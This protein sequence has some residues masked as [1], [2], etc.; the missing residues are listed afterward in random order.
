M[1]KIFR[2][3]IPQEVIEPPPSLPSEV[4]LR[5]TANRRVQDAAK[6]YT[7]G[8]PPSISLG[9]WSERPSLNVQIKT[10]TDYK[11]GC[12]NSPNSPSGSSTSGARTVV[13]LNGGGVRKRG[14]KNFWFSKS[15][16][17]GEE[18]RRTTC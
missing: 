13:N 12:S 18:R 9:S 16:K 1:P 5:E 11:F 15:N 17:R 3:E 6:R 7:Y 14:K 4:K 10:D 2:Q 8:G